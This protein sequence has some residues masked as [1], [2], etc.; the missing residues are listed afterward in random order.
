MPEHARRIKIRR[1]MLRRPDEFHTLTNRAAAWVGGHRELTGG[2]ALGV[3]VVAAVV[4]GISQYRSSQVDRAAESFRAAQ[5]TFTAGRFADAA[6]AFQAVTES[7][8]RTP[9]GRLADLYR[10]HALARQGDATGAATVYSEYLATGPGT[11]YLRQ[12]ALDGL[13]HARESAQDTAAALDAYT[14]AAALDGPYR[15]DALLGAARLQ[16]A[17]G[18]GDAAREIYTRLLKESQPDP[19]LR[20]LLLSKLPPGTEAPPAAAGGRSLV[21][22]P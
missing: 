15:A 11:G 5:A 1:K 20:T 16:E 6:A 9:S 18:H 2:I 3:L 21:E 8:P 19:D 22:F 10:A 12:E 17:G 14:Q 4:L 7:Y 13:A